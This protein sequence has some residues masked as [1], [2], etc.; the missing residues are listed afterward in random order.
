MI[1]NKK[2]S[3]FITHFSLKVQSGKNLFCLLDQ[4]ITPAGLQYTEHGVGVLQ[5]AD[6]LSEGWGKGV[7]FMVSFGNQRRLLQQ[8]L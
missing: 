4:H 5:F 2:T 3:I 1:S 8:K 7:P 6:V